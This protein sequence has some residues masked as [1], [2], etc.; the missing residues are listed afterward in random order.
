MLMPFAFPG[1]SASCFN[2]ILQHMQG[3][4]HF[5][6]GPGTGWLWKGEAWVQGYGTTPCMVDPSK[7]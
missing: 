3:G 6:E 4:E 7:G 5:P 2:K 1:G